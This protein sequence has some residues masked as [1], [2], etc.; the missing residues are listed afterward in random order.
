[1]NFWNFFESDRAY[2]V[3][4]PMYTGPRI[5]LSHNNLCFLVGRTIRE[6]KDLFLDIVG[7]Y[8]K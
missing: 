6:P 4:V 2:E 8:L 1:M 3:P 7:W 5:K